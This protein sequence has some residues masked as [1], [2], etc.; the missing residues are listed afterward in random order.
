MEMK[1]NSQL[2][3]SKLRQKQN[4]L[5]KNKIAKIKVKKVLNIGSF[6]LEKDMEGMFYKDYFPHSQ[7]FTLDKNR[8]ED[9]PNHFNQDAHNLSSIKTKFDLIL[10]MNLLEHV[11]NPAVIT[12]EIKRILMP[13]GYIFVV[14]P[15]FYP[16][17]KNP[18]SG[19]SDYWRFTDDGLRWLFKDYQ[20]KWIKE[21][22]SV[23][24]VVNDIGRYWNNQAAV[25][26]YCALFKNKSKKNAPI[27]KEKLSKSK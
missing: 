23:I 6:Q 4:Q 2:K 5:L 15:F 7:Y 21:I 20:E 26:G 16:I 14:S 10:L 27:S 11:K 12:G 8:L 18:K 25:C 22:D 17:H 19:F 9:H 1:V 24:T 3:I 13:G